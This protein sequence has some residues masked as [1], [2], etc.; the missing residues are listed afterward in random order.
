MPKFKIYV[1]GYNPTTNLKLI[2]QYF[3]RRCQGKISICRPPQKK[4]P[5]N[6]P[7]CIIIL[8][9]EEDYLHILNGGPYIFKGTSLHIDVYVNKRNK[10]K[11]LSHARK[12]AD[13]PLAA[14]KTVTRL[15]SVNGS[16][17][18]VA[19]LGA[20]TRWTR[21]YLA[22]SL[23]SFGTVTDVVFPNFKEI[24]Q[25][26]TIL[27]ENGFEPK[28]IAFVFFKSSQSCDRLL[29]NVDLQV[30]RIWLRVVNS[31]IF[32]SSK[33]HETNPRQNPFHPQ[34]YFGRTQHLNQHDFISTSNSRSKNQINERH[35]THFT[36]L[37]RSKQLIHL[38]TSHN[39]N[40]PAEGYQQPCNNLIRNEG[41]SS[42]LNHKLEETDFSTIQ[43]A[44]KKSKFLNHQPQNLRFVRSTNKMKAFA[45]RNS[46]MFESSLIGNFNVGNQF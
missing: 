24:Q 25:F 17:N 37:E 43:K 35:G 18:C 29:A 42:P 19:L 14:R 3:K 6:T 41:N 16:E 1:T 7:Y 40:V 8:Q 11:K 38:E 44:L 45:F 10:A 46:W 34:P 31:S 23:A 33:E 39:L 13:A 15:L 20:D 30:D 32:E 12:G 36:G 28:N 27:M 4:A 5:K 9:S 2:H 22:R 26:K 21:Q